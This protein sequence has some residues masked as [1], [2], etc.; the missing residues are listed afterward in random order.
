MN[1][2]IKYLAHSDNDSLHHTASDPGSFI[3]PVVAILLYLLVQFFVFKILSK[4][5][6]TKLIFP[7]ILSY[8]LIVAVLASLYIP[9]LSVI[10]ISVGITFALIVTIA[11]LS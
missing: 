8:N 1:S 3:Y 2:P 9:I 5:H 10:A 4:H 6:K 11:S 7:V